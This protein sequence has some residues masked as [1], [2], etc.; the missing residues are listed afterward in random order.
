MKMSKETI[1]IKWENEKTEVEEMKIREIKERKAKATR[2]LI[3]MLKTLL[4]NTLDFNT[5]IDADLFNTS[6]IA[7]FCKENKLRFVLSHRGDFAMVKIKR[8]D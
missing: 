5:V 1:N 8:F 4:N 2:E 7:E 6:E 3:G